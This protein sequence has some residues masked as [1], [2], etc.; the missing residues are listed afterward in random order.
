MIIVS[1][2]MANS[3]IQY[4]EVQYISARSLSGGIIIRALVVIE[5]VDLAYYC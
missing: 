5:I 3:N 1:C 4:F 2:Q